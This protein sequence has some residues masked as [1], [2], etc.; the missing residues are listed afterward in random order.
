MIPFSASAKYL[1]G[2]TAGLWC[3]LVLGS[4]CLADEADAQKAGADAA[5]AQEEPKVP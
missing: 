1:A 4:S 2:L 5:S 3:M